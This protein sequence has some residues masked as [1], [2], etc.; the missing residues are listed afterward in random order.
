MNNILPNLSLD[1]L[2]AW[3]GEGLCKMMLYKLL[4]FLIINFA[5]A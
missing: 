4:S 3:T 5:S 1:L 2:I